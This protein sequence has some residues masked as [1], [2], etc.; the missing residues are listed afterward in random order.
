M[1]LPNLLSFR[2]PVKIILFGTGMLLSVA[3]CGL[4]IAHTR[5]FSL[6]RD[7]AVMIGTTLPELRSTVALLKANQEA[8]Q[9]FFRN[10]LSARE[11]Q[12]S[13]YV[14][15]GGPAATRAVNVLQSIIRVLRE[16]GGNQ[17]SIDTIAF[18]E[19]ASDRGEYKTVGATLTMTGDF[20]F[21]ARFLSILAMSGNMMIRDIFTDDASAAFLK[22]VNDS[23]PLSLKA[24]EDFLYTDLLTYAAE[25]D[26]TEQAMLQDIPED[27]QPD[28][29]AFVLSSGLAGV[30]NSLSDIAPSLKKERIWPLPFLTVDSLKRDGQRWEIGL[31]F[32][33]R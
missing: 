32:Y 19:K 26:Q 31:T 15:P 2:R 8:E 9:Y 4:L 12:A 27:V 23:A 11:E 24:A 28:I 17:G 3:A 20:R 16:L 14:L 30:R 29:R 21:V 18:Q 7:T 13:V 6:K 25:P 5:S 33:R 22:Q 1:P 10:A